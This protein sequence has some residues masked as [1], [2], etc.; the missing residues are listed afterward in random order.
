[1][2]GVAVVLN[3]AL[4]WLTYGMLELIYGGEGGGGADPCDVH[5]YQHC[6]IW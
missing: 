5:E 6:H 4:V 2:W 3:G 1:M